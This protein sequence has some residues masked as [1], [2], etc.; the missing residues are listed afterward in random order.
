MKKDEII[1]LLK[2]GDVK[3]KNLWIKVYDEELEKEGFISVSNIL[4][5]IVE[6]VEKLT[7]KQGR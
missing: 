7:Q 5:T 6:E 2:D 4:D 3:I 1:E